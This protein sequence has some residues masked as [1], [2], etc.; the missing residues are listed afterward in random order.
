M[1][2]VRELRPVR[3]FLL[4]TLCLVLAGCWE[5]HKEVTVNPDGTA[6]I[7]VVRD[8]SLDAVKQMQ[9][10]QGSDLEESARQQAAE[11]VQSAQGV[12]A[13]S[14]VEW[15]VQEEVIRV[16]G[17]AYVPD[18][19]EF[20]LNDPSGDDDQGFTALDFRRTDSGSV[21]ELTMAGEDEEDQ[22]EPLPSSLTHEQ[23][24]EMARKVKKENRQM[25]AM[26]AG[27][28]LDMYEEVT[29]HLPAEPTE[30]DGFSR[31]EDGAYTASFAGE[32]L[33]SAIGAIID[34]PTDS[35]A[36]HLMA[37]AEA[38]KGRERA[39]GELM[40][41]RL[42]GIP[43]RVV[44]PSPGE[45]QFD[46]QAEVAEARES[47]PQLEERLGIGQDEGP[48]GG[49]E[50][51]EGEVTVEAEADEA[52]GG[53]GEPGGGGKPAGAESE[54]GP[55][56][57]EGPPRVVRLQVG[58]PDVSSTLELGTTVHVTLP[59]VAGKQ[60]LGL[61]AE[62]PEGLS[63][64]DDQGRELVAVSAQLRDSWKEDNPNHFTSRQAT[65]W[66]LTTVGDDPEIPAVEISLWAA[67][68]PGARSLRI[69]GEVPV[70]TPPTSTETATVAA[71]AI[72]DG[73]S[74]ELGGHE[75]TLSERAT[76][77]M[78]GER[79]V[80][81]EVDGDPV[82]VEI[83]RKGETLWQLGDRGGARISVPEDLTGDEPLTFVFGEPAVMR[84]PLDLRFGIGLGGGGA[85]P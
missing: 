60:H 6:R 79:S 49:P 69:Q 66:S 46:Y 73:A 71:S 56:Q 35:L 3:S 81:Y 76:M 62:T 61:S 1:K 39:V 25:R 31:G 47:Y 75:V 45:Q 77:T 8:V 84:V 17:T 48:A 20:S 55:I 37:A 26:A 18:L 33:V 44:I 68:S 30:V 83:R 64:T 70:L 72:S 40:L 57:V 24:V 27:M 78:G 15:S 22:G 21:I 9:M 53:G 12:E 13:W 63:V 11:M 2:L 59:S 23:A 74:L 85:T 29:L 80:I 82:V 52:A 28:L 4:L 41:D 43:A 32:K 42:E 10:G 5:V 58:R 50:P 38:G 54:E 67:P 51:F 19:G 36:S 34:M 65:S 7:R 16:Q 14:D